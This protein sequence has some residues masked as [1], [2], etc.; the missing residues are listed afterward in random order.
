MGPPGCDYW[1]SNILRLQYNAMQCNAM[2]CNGSPRSNFESTVQ[3]CLSRGSPVAACAK[4]KGNSPKYQNFLKPFLQISANICKFKLV[5]GPLGLI[6]SPCF[7]CLG[8]EAQNW[9]L[10][11]IKP[12]FYEIA[13]KLFYSYLSIS[14][15]IEI[16][17]G[18]GKGRHV[19]Y[20]VEEGV[21]GPWKGSEGSWNS[22]SRLKKSH[23][24]KPVSE[25]EPEPYCFPCFRWSLIMVR[26]SS[27]FWNLLSLIHTQVG[28]GMLVIV[29]VV[30]V[31]L[32]VDWGRG[33][34]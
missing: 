31:Q 17:Q 28:L 24:A 27:T 22:S 4:W 16:F 11:Q 2:Q 21:E 10:H 19:T 6:L 20:R 14:I 3:S 13:K 23:Q 29:L 25:K 15:F 5:L 33:T 30:M 26:L 8:Y 12:T 18:G 7:S 1:Q 32:L 34:A 9:T